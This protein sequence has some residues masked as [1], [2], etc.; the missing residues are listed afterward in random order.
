[1]IYA[2]IQQSRIK[3]LYSKHLRVLFL[4][5]IS[6]FAAIYTSIAVADNI[7]ENIDHNKQME[8]IFVSIT[9]LKNHHEDKDIV[10]VD[11]RTEKEYKKGHILNAVNIPMRKT[12]KPTKNIYK[13]GGF[14]QIKKL[15]SNAGIEYGKH[16]IVYGDSSY[17]NASRVFYVFEAYGHQE[18]S[19]LETGFPG[20]THNS[21]SLIS[22]TETI[23][24]KSD[25]RPVIDPDRIVSKFEMQLAIN[26]D[27]KIIIDS[28]PVK[29][30]LGLLSITDRKGKI[31]SAINIPATSNYELADGLRHV[32]PMEDLTAL[33]ANIN[34]NK[35]IY[36]YCNEGLEASRTYSILRKLGFDVAQYDGSWFE[37]GSD[38]KLPI[39]GPDSSE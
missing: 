7:A 3:I 21:D 22:M 4:T 32:K 34:K 37:W 10:I 25:Y 2:I 35:K 38:H 20:W 27:D 1:M 23:I 26:D 31:P 36:L 12:Y 39:E 9:W 33:Y 14:K 17:F 16:I 28:R 30:Y 8:P 29:H 11:S 19:I 15:F 6:L 5:V 18:I 13:M 24:D